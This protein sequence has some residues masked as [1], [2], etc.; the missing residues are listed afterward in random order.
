MQGRPA[1]IVFGVDVRAVIE[2][3]VNGFRILVRGCC[4]MQGR[5]AVI[6]LRLDVCAVVQQRLNDGLVVISA[7]R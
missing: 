2:Q 7:W 5:A 6:I 1:V 4:E 3:P